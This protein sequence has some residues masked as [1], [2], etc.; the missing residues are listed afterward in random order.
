MFHKINQSNKETTFIHLFAFLGVIKGFLKELRELHWMGLAFG[1]LHLL[2]L[3]LAG[4]IY[5]L[6]RWVLL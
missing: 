1:L 2:P 5:G 4:V 6:R 3:D